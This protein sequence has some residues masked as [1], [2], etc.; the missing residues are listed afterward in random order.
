MLAL[1][2][3]YQ[4]HGASRTRLTQ[5]KVKHTFPTHASEQLSGFHGGKKNHKRESAIEVQLNE[6][7]RA[8]SLAND[9]SLRDSARARAK[10]NARFT[11]VRCCEGWLCRARARRQ[12]L[13]YR[14]R[15]RRRRARHESAAAG[16]CC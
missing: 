7:T 13:L 4:Y 1:Q 9:T 15:R 16:R 12:A 14:R 6:P 8:E 2:L 10:W 3:D 11:C 5:L